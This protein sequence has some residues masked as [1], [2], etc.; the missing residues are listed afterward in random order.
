MAGLQATWE[1]LG[2]T[3][4]AGSMFD[5]FILGDTTDPDIWVAE[6]AAYL[7]LLERTAGNGRIF[8]RRRPRNAARKAGNISEWVC[9]FGAAYPQS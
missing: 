9:R 5:L 4:A 2:A 7:A 1:S 3:R 8:Y 6:E